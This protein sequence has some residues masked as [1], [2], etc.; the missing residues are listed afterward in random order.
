LKILLTGHSGFIGTCLQNKLRGKFDFVTSA[1]TEEGQRID[2][3]DKT[4]LEALEGLDTVIHLASKTSIPESIS[5]PYDTYLTNIVGT[6]NVLNSAAKNNIK[7]IINVSTYVYG[8]PKYNPID[9]NHPLAPHSP[10]NKSKLIAE[11]LCKYYS[12]DF[13]LNIVTLRPFYIYGHSQ[14]SSF[15]SSAIK[16]VVNH[17]TVVLSNKNIHRDFLFVDDF[18]SLVN[19]ILLNFPPGYNVYNIG[20]GKSYTLEEVVKIIE[21]I[22]GKKASLKYNYALRPND[23][24]EMVAN[25]NKVMK[26]FDWEPTIDLH[27]GIRR[28][29][30]QHY[31]NARK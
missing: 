3:L 26:K 23:I 14:K 17:E 18:V 21:S 16:K 20:S 22:V 29:I 30:D 6:L 1:S 10:Y 7:N 11:N 9:E 31:S 24:T 28:T 12:E 25:I 8:S 13:K 4:E 27:E 15:L 2:V 19:K 5:N